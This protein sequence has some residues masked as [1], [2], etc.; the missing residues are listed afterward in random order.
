MITDS[1]IRSQLVRG[2]AAF[3]VSRVIGHARSTIADTIYA[4]TVDS[5]LAGVS[6]RMAERI[7]LTPPTT[8]AARD[9]P[10]PPPRLRVIDGGRRA[11]GKD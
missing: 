3:N 2:E 9:P 10:R 4:H 6:E 5:A 8:P 1:G 7:G 11:K